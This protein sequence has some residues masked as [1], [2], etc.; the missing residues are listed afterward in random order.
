MTVLRFNA[1]E[2][3]EPAAWG[4]GAGDRPYPVELIEQCQIGPDRMTI[5]PIQPEDAAEHM[6]FFGRISS[7]DVRY[8]F[9]SA[10]REMSPEMTARLTR[11]DYDREMAFIAV[12]ETNGQ[13]VGVAR[14]VGDTDGRSGEFAVIV[15]ADMKGRGLATHLMHRLIA[16]ARARGLTE[17][18]GQILADNQ[19]M[20]AFIRHRGFTVHR[21]A[22]DPEV[23]EARLVL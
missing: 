17:V 7:Q 22:D 5:R 15:Q 6:A 9:F 2:C 10:M 8:R 21:M 20:L 19:P 11:I 14:L 1:T 18:V 16:W 13:T 12:N 23:M 3:L 4:R